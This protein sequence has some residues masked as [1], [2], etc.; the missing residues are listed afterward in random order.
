MTA[1]P[2]IDR[3]REAYAA[4]LW[5]DAYDHLSIADEEGALTAHDLDNL[6]RSAY[7]SGR[8]AECVEIWSRAHHAFLDEDEAR[9][10]SACAFWLG[11]TLYNQGE[12]AQGNGWMARARRLVEA[13][14][15]ECAERGFLLIPRGLQLL[16]EGNPVEAH[17]VF[18][19][20]AAI[21]ERCESFDLIML[22]R[23]G[24]GQ[25]L[26]HQNKIEKGV[27]LL[28]EAMVGVISDEISPIVAGIVYCAVID[29][30]HKIYDL[31]RAQEW[32]AALSHWCDSQPDLIPY[33]GQCLVRR[34]EIMQLQGNWPDALEEARRASDLSEASRPSAKG[35]AF[36]RQAELY[37]LKGQFTNAEQA[38]REA[39]R[40]GRKPQPGLALLRLAQGQQEAAEAAIRL[41]EEERKSPIERSSLLPAFVDILLDTG[42]LEAARAADSELSR[43]AAEL[44]APYLSAVADR[45]H[46]RVL[47][48]TEDPARALEVLRR[49]WTLFKELGASYEAARTRELIAMASA[50]LGDNDT[51]EMELDA[52]RWVFDQLGAAPDL[53]R[54]E[55]LL[56]GSNPENIFGLTPRELE[57]LEYL[58][59]GKTNKEIAADLFIS[60]RTVDRHVSNILAKLDVASRAAATA[61]AYRHHLV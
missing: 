22:G 37:R 12:S 2:A 39:T 42:D 29:T 36:Y 35:D 10:A 27:L 3:G 18:G 16:R 30:C 61:F 11:L 57:V 48:A 6:A 50:E 21:G 58:A 25:A 49:A 13:F 38:Y 45:A 24:R 47:L 43:I 5:A 60:E 41:E 15:E 14:P 33:R 20:A 9:K 8:E 26:I 59:T 40:R 7:L 17:D 28:D 44:N 4:H 53:L 34:A 55:S 32:T 54:V 46:G 23:L 1:E 56:G 31:K 19:H 52:A 51:A